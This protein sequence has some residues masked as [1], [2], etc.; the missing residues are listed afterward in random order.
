MHQVIVRDS[1][2]SRRLGTRNSRDISHL[3]AFQGRSGV[4][5]LP[6]A[7][8]ALVVAVMIDIHDVT[9]A[10]HHLWL[11]LGHG[12]QCRE[13]VVAVPAHVLA[14]EVPKKCQPECAKQGICISR[15]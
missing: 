4:R 8:L 14:S 2:A 5:D 15:H 11:V 7:K 12:M 1:T 3:T 6:I 9:E 10:N 13:A